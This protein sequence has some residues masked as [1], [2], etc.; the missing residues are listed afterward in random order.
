[1][2]RVTAVLLAAVVGVH[3]LRYLLA[4][5]SDTSAV[6]GHTGHGYM[7]FAVPLI[8][9]STVLALAQLVGGTLGVQRLAAH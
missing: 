4:F 2:L 1:V 8:G 3:Q 7:S 9:I 6:L 5:G